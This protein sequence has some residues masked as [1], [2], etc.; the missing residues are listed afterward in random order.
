MTAAAIKRRATVIIFIGLS[1]ETS[2]RD[3]SRHDAPVS[4]GL[5]IQSLV[6]R[7]SAHCDNAEERGPE[8][9]DSRVIMAQL[10]NG[11]LSRVETRYQTRVLDR[12]VR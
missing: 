4:V 7:A 2:T 1:L 8:H 10:R 11:Q 6:G 9:D 12:I 5:N 3:E